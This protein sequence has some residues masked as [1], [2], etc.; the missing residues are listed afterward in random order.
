MDQYVLDLSDPDAPAPVEV[1]PDGF[2][3][4]LV[5]PPLDD[6]EAWFR[7]HDDLES[8]FATLIR[9]A[10]DE[11]IDGGRTGR[12]SLAQL[13][14]TEKTYIGT[15]I[16]IL[17]RSE[18]ELPRQKPMD[19]T[20]AGHPVDVKWSANRS[21]WQIP[22]EAIG[23]ICLLLCGDE[24]HQRFEVGLVRCSEAHLNRGKNK[25][26][27]TTLSAD[28]RAAIRWL[29]RGTLALNF[30]ATLPAS[31]RDEVMAQ[32]KGQPRVTR[33]FSLVQR[34]PV[35]RL[36]IVTVAQQGGDP[37]RRIRKDKRDRLQGL[38]V[39]GGHYKK[40]RQIVET[41]GYPPLGKDEYMSLPRAELQAHGFDDFD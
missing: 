4:E 33:L 3:P 5:D 30:L 31:V 24:T 8:T 38:V 10:L 27:K 40:T 9:Q 32:P 35:P 16:E 1:A 11:V 34:K 39:L 6:V 21:G 22:T 12:W 17:V 28:G 26:Q 14:S 13:E 15:K 23:H 29:A 41:L 18:F 7:S 2:E 25:D 19:T 36:A 37:M 20:I